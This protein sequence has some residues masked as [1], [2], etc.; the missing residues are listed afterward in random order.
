MK[1]TVVLCVGN[2]DGGDDAVGP[3]IA[4][5]L[6]DYE[7]DELICIDA[8]IAPENFTGVVKQYQPDRLIIVDA[9][10]MGIQPGE[11]R[12][13]P[14]NRIGVMHM[15]THGIPL[16]VLVKYFNQYV[17]TIEIIGIQ[18]KTM[19]GNI[20]ERIKKAGKE[21]TMNITMNNIE[22]ISMLS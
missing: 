9:I 10:E 4:D 18:P 2:R 19:N 1:K 22:K 14:S 13:V 5:L 12:R 6:H 3:F 21:L 20:T 11:I 7:S 15:S 8:G 17:S 16:S